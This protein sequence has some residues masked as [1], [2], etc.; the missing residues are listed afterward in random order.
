MKNKEF[1]SRLISMILTK[2]NRESLEDINLTRLSERVKI[3]T[4][5]FH[6]WLTGAFP[7]R[8][9]HWEKIQNY[10]DCD[11]TYLIA[12]VVGDKQVIP[13]EGKITISDD[14]NKLLEC[15]YK[16]RKGLKLNCPFK[17]N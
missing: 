1:T 5:T 7:K 2:E 11:L 13:D 17:F 6:Q 14:K 9:E 12:G 8:M 16:I 10:F 15:S 3:P 4:A